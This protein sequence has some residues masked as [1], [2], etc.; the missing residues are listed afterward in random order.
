MT[1]YLIAREDAGET[2]DREIKQRRKETKKKKRRDNAAARIQELRVTTATQLSTG[3]P[4][5]R[6]AGE[7]NFLEGKRRDLAQWLLQKEQEERVLPGRSPLKSLSS[8]IASEAEK[9]FCGNR[10]AH[11]SAV[12][13]E[14][15]TLF[16][17]RI[18]RI[19]CAG[20]YC[21][22]MRV[23]YSG[24]VAKEASLFAAITT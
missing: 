20:R 4:R 7:S 6:V 1:P 8:S 16:V 12:K 19:F 17:E 15:C 13:S 10:V 3:G 5:A 18:P 24:H 22:R 21:Q 23:I 14:S 11:T 2:S 9:R